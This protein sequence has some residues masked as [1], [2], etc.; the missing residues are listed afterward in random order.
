MFEHN[1]RKHVS[2]VKSTFIIY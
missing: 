2:S 1:L